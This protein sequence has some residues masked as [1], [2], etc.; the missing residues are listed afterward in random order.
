MVEDKHS[1]DSA[2]FRECGRI[3]GRKQELP[4][5]SNKSHAETFLE[6]CSVGDACGEKVFGSIHIPPL[7]ERPPPFLLRVDES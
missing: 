7:G 4:R 3:E 6:L 1:S 2:L 5:I